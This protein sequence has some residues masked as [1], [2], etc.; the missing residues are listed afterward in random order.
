MKKFLVYSLV[1]CVFTSFF[2]C[3][4]DN[5]APIVEVTIPP[6][7]SR[8]VIRADWAA[9]SD[10]LAVFVS[11]SRGTLDKTPFN[12]PYGCDTVANS[13]VELLRNGQSL[14]TIPYFGKAYHYRKG[15]FK[16]DTLA[17]AVYTIRVSAPDLETVEASQT[18][19]NPFVVL[20][21]GYRR[22]GAVFTDPSDPF[23]TPQKGDELSVEFQ[24]NGAD[25]NYYSLES[26]SRFGGSYISIA[27][28][29]ANKTYI[30][31][32]YVQDLDPNIQNG[33]LPDQAFNGKTYLWRFW[34]QTSLYFQ[35]TLGQ[36]FFQGRISKGDRI[37]LRARLTN[38]DFVA[39][40]KSMNL[41]RD[42]NDNPFFSEPVILYTNVKKG[43]GIFT[44]S[45]FQTI[46][47][48]VP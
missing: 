36:G 44:I 39:F 46:S 41:A 37:S 18:I 29:S 28:D 26:N 27:R 38:K 4:E 32:T 1:L 40:A 3:N 43:Y 34:V 5:F 7:T 12:S 17:G 15:L 30:S 47:F 22:D 19:Q 21:G 2:A 35:N 10:S 11:K 45:R 25:D 31:S 33:F 48:V 9:G 20:R 14:G 24:D 8:L 13:K 16:L 23:T 42:V 6:H